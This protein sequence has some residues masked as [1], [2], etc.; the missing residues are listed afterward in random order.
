MPIDF[1]LAYMDNMLWKLNIS[2][3]S[4]RDKIMMSQTFK[5]VIRKFNC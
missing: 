1:L 3:A 5:G 4:T 2:E